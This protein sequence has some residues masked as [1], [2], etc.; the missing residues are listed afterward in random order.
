MPANAWLIA[1]RK[2][3]SSFKKSEQ[4]RLNSSGVDE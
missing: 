2:I 3:L 4:A 1:V